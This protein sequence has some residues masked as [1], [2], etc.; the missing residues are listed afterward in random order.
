MTPGQMM[1]FAGAILIALWFGGGQ[2]IKEAN[3]RKRMEW[4]AECAK[5]N[6]PH[7]CEK[8]FEKAERK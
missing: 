7:D 6:D 5:F 8:L 4:A 2:I 3:K 1:L